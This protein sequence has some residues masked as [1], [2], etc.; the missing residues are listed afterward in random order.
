M[1]RLLLA[2]FAV[3]LAACGAGA[4]DPQPFEGAFTVAA[5]GPDTTLVSFETTGEDAE[6]GTAVVVDA[7]DAATTRWDLGLLGTQV[8]LNGGSSG[9]GGAVGTVVDVA[10]DAVA[11]ALA[12]DYVYRR[13]GESPCPTGPPRAVCTG[14]GDGLFRTVGEA[15][16]PVPG[17]TLL[18]RLGDG[19]GY[20]EVAV[21]A[22]DA[23][24]ATYTLR[25]RVN[26]D[27]SSFQVDA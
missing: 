22:Y 15:V 14:D 23:A 26:P 5:P 11:D 9:P 10:F 17:R 7:A 21:E 25:Y 3:A 13:D 1:P 2:V 8:F 4:P 16:E 6:T 12:D 27:G 18:L 19:Q 24:T 20:A